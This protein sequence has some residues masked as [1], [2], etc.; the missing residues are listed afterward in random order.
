MPSLDRRKLRRKAQEVDL[1]AA[2]ISE[3]TLPSLDNLEDELRAAGFTE[4]ADMEKRAKW[5]LSPEGMEAI[6]RKYSKL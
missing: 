2:K 3:P 1:E 6:E 4:L 5:L